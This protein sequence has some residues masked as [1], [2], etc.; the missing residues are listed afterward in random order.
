MRSKKLKGYQS[1]KQTKIDESKGE[2]WFCSEDEAK[3]AGW[4]KALN[5][6]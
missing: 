1:Y 2:E 5:C 3:S 6:S 4:R